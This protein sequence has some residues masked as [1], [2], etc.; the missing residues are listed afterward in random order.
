MT[1]YELHNLILEQRILVGGAVETWLLATSGLL[2]TAYFV[3]SNLDK[4]L[5]RMILLIYVFACAITGLAWVDRVYGIFDYTQRL[6]AIGGV[7][8][9]HPPFVT[10]LAVGLFVV[11]FLIGSTGAVRYFFSATSSRTHNK[12]IQPT[13]SGGD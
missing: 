11:T 2:V 3:G 4:A 7:P 12:S 10:Q 13:A 6:D 1:E 5:S 8:L 9:G